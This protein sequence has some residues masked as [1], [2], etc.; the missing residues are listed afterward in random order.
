LWQNLTT[1]S[2]FGGMVTDAADVLV[3]NT[4][5]GQ[6]TNRRCR[7]RIENRSDLKF[8]IEGGMSA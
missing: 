7:C 5:V 6:I 4:A 8:E 3:R 1:D 2:A